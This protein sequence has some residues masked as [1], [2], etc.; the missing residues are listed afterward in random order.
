[1]NLQL[2]MNN[3]TG[4]PTV[5]MTAQSSKERKDMASFLAT[6]NALKDP[7]KGAKTIAVEVELESVSLVATG[8][9]PKCVAQTEAREK[10]ARAKK[11]GR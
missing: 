5:K 11:A 3:D 9:N 2:S 7:K 8:V 6:A 4:A 10:A 1:M